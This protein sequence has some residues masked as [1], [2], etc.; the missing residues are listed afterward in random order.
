MMSCRRSAC[1]LFAVLLAT[2]PVAATAQREVTVGPWTAQVGDADLEALSYQGQLVVQKGGMRAYL[3]AWEGARFDMNGAN[4]EVTETSGTWHKAEAGNQ[5]ATLKLELTPQSAKYSLET[6]ITAAGPTEYW[7]QIVPEAVRSDD[8]H[9]LVW[10]DGRLRSL[11]LVG[12]FER[13]GGIRELRF[14][15]ADRTVIVRCTGFELQD[16]RA[17]GSGLFLVRVIGSSGEQPRTVASTIEIEV[18]EAE[19]EAVAG[20]EAL[21]AQ[22]PVEYHPLALANADLEADEPLAS[23]SPN[24]LAA[25]DTDIKHAG[26]QAA[27]LTIAGE[28]KED[29]R[30]RVYLIQ[31]VPVEEGKLYQA[32]A[33]IR[34]QDVKRAVVTHMSSVGATVIL[35]FA[36]KQGEW[37]AGG[38]Y[39]KSHYGTFD[40]RRVL[41]D[42]VRA[43]KGA[44]YAIVYLALRATGTAWFDDVALR[45]VR[46]HVLMLDPLP[47]QQVADNTP[48]FNWHFG[49][50]TWTTLELCR[51]EHFAAGETVALQ[52]VEVPPVALKSPIE[53]GQWFWRVRV[54][55]YD[56]VSP[57]WRFTQTASL[58]QDCT[59][60]EIAETHGWL[61]SKSAPMRVRYSDNVG[62]VKVSLTVDGQDV[63]AAVQ[64]GAEQAVYV[65]E[66]GWSEGLHKALIRA[67]DAAGN[68]AERQLFFTHSAELPRTTW[69]QIGGVDTQG[70]RRFLL[71][72]YGVKIEHMP[73]IAAGGFDFVHSYQ[74]D[75][76]GSN[77][78]ALEYLDE[79]QKHGLQA[80]VGIYRRRLMSGDEEFV[81]ERVGALMHHPA[82]FAWY[83]YDEPDLQHQYVSPMWL[84][85]YYKLIKALDPFHPVVVTCAGDGAVEK[86]RDA[87]DVHWTQ[88]YGSTA[89]VSSRIDRHR[90]SLHEGT[91]LAAILHC[92]DRAQTSVVRGGGQADPAEFQPDGRMMRA[93]A[94][95]AL[96]HNS[97]CLIWWWWGYG[98][99]ETMFT[100][101]N[102]PK[103][104]ASLQQTVADIKSLRPVLTAAGEIHTW[105]ETPAED[106][107]VHIWEKR[108]PDPTVII[109]VNRDETPSELSFAPKTLP[110]DCRVKV[111]FEDREVE[112]KEGL[113]TDSFEELAVHVYEWEA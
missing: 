75:G 108:L 18:Q 7:V 26:E 43:P 79:A 106:V 11:P 61:A 32:Q 78:E 20:R 39:G 105:V 38:S 81:A 19:P 60:P 29:E 94:F 55:D 86:Y 6:T 14:E 84:A 72:M 98:G 28:L 110:R 53:P 91:P 99:G 87:L 42:P 95:M 2:W 17:Q 66:A 77:E 63:S 107:E 46:Y 40:W 88:V 58:D 35:E 23:W 93:N 50:K 69:Q 24:P 83:L 97:S 8:E 30:G 3:P 65:P 54:P 100:V 4:L 10:V 103:E 12:E 27:R 59:E 47:G 36:D 90:A 112:V 73:E 62:V 89:F 70:E 45:E 56:L 71:G 82:L 22:L 5:D 101:A 57:A 13:F 102:A 80:F 15:R 96:A 48:R 67:E 109:A 25:V 37:F 68:Y 74:W 52:D 16:R 92:Y 76:A 113:L 111:L 34:G 21:I 85:R 44:G 49:P 104:W 64:V 41:T 31:T 51:S 1:G 33:W 9:C